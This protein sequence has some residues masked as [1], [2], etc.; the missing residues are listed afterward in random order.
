MILYILAILITVLAI[1]LFYFVYIKTIGV[2]NPISERRELKVKGVGGNVL[3]LKEGVYQELYQE[4]LDVV[5]R[6][7][8]VNIK[9]SQ[10]DL[11][12]DV[13]NEA[14]KLNHEIERIAE[15]SV[16]IGLISKGAT[17]LTIV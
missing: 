14:I 1:G 6:K 4:S 16:S 13:Q 8:E 11:S 2:H 3:S 12:D 7:N 9:V 15:K 10:G 5:L 17:K